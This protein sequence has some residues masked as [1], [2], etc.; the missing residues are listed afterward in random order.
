MA[1]QWPVRRGHRVLPATPSSQRVNLT[2]STSSREVKL[3]GSAQRAVD[4]HIQAGGGRVL[5]LPGLGRVRDADGQSPPL[6][7]NSRRPPRW[8]CHAGSFLSQRCRRLGGHSQGIHFVRDPANGAV[9]TGYTAALY[10]PA[11]RTGRYSLHLFDEEEHKK[12]AMAAPMTTSRVS[13]P[14]SLSRTSSCGLRAAGAVTAEL[15]VHTPRGGI[16]RRLARR[17]GEVL[18]VSEM[19]GPSPVR[20][21]L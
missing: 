9:T 17:Q 19:C 21:S 6:P 14:T 10:Q 18:R 15:Q 3:T 2:C 13:T 20:E 12:T 11:L 4:R 8:R 1:G 5:V 16:F 7:P